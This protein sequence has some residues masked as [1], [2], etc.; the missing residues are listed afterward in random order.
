MKMVVVVV[1]IMDAA[2]G[3]EELVRMFRQAE[4]NNQIIHVYGNGRVGREA[5][6]RRERTMSCT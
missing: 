1:V 4:R 6:H 3:L 2:K 5:S